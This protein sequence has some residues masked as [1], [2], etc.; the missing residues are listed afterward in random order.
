MFSIDVAVRARALR[1]GLL[2]LVLSFLVAGVSVAGDA[3]PVDT[4]SGSGQS[5]LA[6]WWE[7]HGDA[8]REASDFFMTVR[9][10]EPIGLLSFALL[11]VLVLP[12]N[13]K[14]VRSFFNQIMSKYP[15]EAFR[16]G[17]VHDEDIAQARKLLFFYCLFLIYQVIQ[18][19]LTLG[20]DGVLPFMADLVFQVL[21]LG[22]LFSAY[23]QL[24]R[25]MRLRWKDDEDR[26]Q[27][28]T[29]WLNSKLEGMNVRIHEMRKLALSVFAVS[30]GPVAIEKPPSLIST[31]VALGV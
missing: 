26:R 6:A 31:L 13:A 14:A 9:A 22:F 27:K 4:T 19:P 11:V 17:R 10:D 21:L 5:P 28:M 20:A 16:K 2:G 25:S 1:S 12:R 30:F 18:M 23:R 29:E 3:G 7:S 24:R 15:L 8:V